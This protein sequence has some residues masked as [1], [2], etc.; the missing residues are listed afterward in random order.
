MQ[1]PLVHRVLIDT[2]ND[3]NLAVSWPSTRAQAPKCRPGAADASRHVL[4]I[5]DEET[6]GVGLL[7]FDTNRIAANI[8]TNKQ[9]GCPVHSDVV[10]FTNHLGQLGVT[11][12]SPVQVPKI[13]Y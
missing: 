6:M 9:R 3:I 8:I 11:R 13:E 1:H 12:R 10:V 4:Y 7:G 2:F 5:D